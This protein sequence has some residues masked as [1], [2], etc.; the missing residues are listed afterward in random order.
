ME[1]GWVI[2]AG[3][4]YRRCWTAGFCPI[5]ALHPGGP[6]LCTN[7]CT[8]PLLY[9][10]KCQVTGTMERSEWLVAMMRIA[11]ANQPWLA[12]QPPEA[13]PPDW[14]N[15]R[16]APP[17]LGA[18]LASQP[19]G[20]LPCQMNS[21]R[22]PT[23]KANPGPISPHHGGPAGPHPCTGLLVIYNKLRDWDILPQN[24]KVRVTSYI[25]TILKCIIGLIVK[26]NNFT[27]KKKSVHQILVK[28]II[29]SFSS[30]ITWGYLDN[31]SYKFCRA[32]IIS[33]FFN[34]ITGSGQ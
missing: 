21:Y 31:S 9:I 4:S 8:G 14:P 26:K 1:L 13:P 32:T 33:T 12:P 17:W 29:T 25:V 7:P 24:L 34:F 15:P 23:P 2:V 28:L 10:Y 5:L 20:F 16:L 30:L 11:M 18:R 3:R 19:L 27:K 6:Y 22:L